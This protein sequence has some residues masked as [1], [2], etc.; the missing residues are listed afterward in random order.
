MLLVNDVARS[1]SRVIKVDT[2]TGDIKAKRDACVV[3]AATSNSALLHD[4]RLEDPGTVVI[5]DADLKTNLYTV[6]VDPVGAA[7]LCAKST[8]DAGINLKRQGRILQVPIPDDPQK[9]T[10]EAILAMPVIS[11]DDKTLLPLIVVPHGGPHSVSLA[12][13]SVA[14]AFLNAAGFATLEVNYRGSL[15]GFDLDALPGHIGERDVADCV[16]ATHAALKAEPRLDATKVGVCGGS[17]GGYLAATLIAAHADLFKVCCLRNPVCNL[18]SMLGTSDIP[19]WV[20]HEG[21][22]VSKLTGSLTS[23]D[24]TQDD[25]AELRRR[26]PITSAAKVTAPTLIA[27]GLSDRRVP[28]SQGIEFFHALTIDKKKLL[29]YSA[30][31]HA[32]DKPWS[33]ADHW[34]HIASWL[35]DHLL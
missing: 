10:I 29:T 16:A 23:A 22:T 27:I 13:W 21:L 12:R 7:S 35:R 6:P 25:L 14:M 4:Q 2:V 18:V 32:I 31:D 34:V 8:W 9:K 26:S 20:L 1:L 11:E 15:G 3:I 17:H 5:A 33:T 19:D 28:P 24:L 30:D